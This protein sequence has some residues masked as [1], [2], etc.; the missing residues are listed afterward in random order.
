MKRFAFI[1]VLLLGIGLAIGLNSNT[2]TPK[3]TSKQ[4]DVCFSPE[5]GIKD[6]I[7]REI[8]LSKNRIDLAIFDFTNQEIAEALKEAKKRNVAIRIIMDSFKAGKK[9]HSQHE[10]LIKNGIDVKLKSGKGSGLM[11]HKFCIFDN[12]L[13]MTGSYNFSK[14]AEYNSYEN[15]VFIPN[16][17]VIK[18]YKDHFQSIWR[19]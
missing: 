8:N 3:D 19:K 5:G 9:D 15:M 17:S 10:Y 12:R 16:Q 7:I 2:E 14:N 4:I 1:F 13:L 18:Q 6:R 11:H